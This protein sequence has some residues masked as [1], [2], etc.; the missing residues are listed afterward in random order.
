MKIKGEIG[1]KVKVTFNT[2]YGENSFIRN[3]IK[4]LKDFIRDENLETA[5]AQVEIIEDNI[6]LY[7]CDIKNSC[8]D[9]SKLRNIRERWA[10][11]DF[12]YSKLCTKEEIKEYLQKGYLIAVAG[13]KEI[14]LNDLE[15][16][17]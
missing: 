1:R 14:D 7:R 9:L 17:A 11:N 3:T 12:D 5:Q 10:R 8:G 4:E 6:I 16:I 2:E 15:K 13:L